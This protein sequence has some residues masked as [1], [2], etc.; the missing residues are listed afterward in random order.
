M[1]RNINVLLIP[2]GLE[3]GRYLQEVIKVLEEDPDFQKKIENITHDQIIVST[4]FYEYSG[5]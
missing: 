3:Y 1:N 2:Q 5:A 4:L